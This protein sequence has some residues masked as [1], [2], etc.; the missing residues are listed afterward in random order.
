MRPGLKSWHI[1]FTFY[2][3]L[4]RHL[5]HHPVLTVFSH[6]KFTY[7]YLI[8]GYNS[9]AQIT[10][11]TPCIFSGEALADVHCGL[12]STWSTAWHFSVAFCPSA[13]FLN[14]MQCIKRLTLL[15]L[16]GYKHLQTLSSQR[17]S[18]LVSDPVC[19][20]TT[21]TQQQCTV[22]INPWAALGVLRIHTLF[23]I[24]KT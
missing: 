17:H 21:P 9:A 11:L 14:L 13:L 7:L 12:F 10:H 20:S 8:F 5:P 18:C 15:T 22:Q 16:Y 19:W 6:C 3:Y 2:V 1:A 23:L 4:F 24:L